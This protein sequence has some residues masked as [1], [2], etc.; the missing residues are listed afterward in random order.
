MKRGIVMEIKRRKAVILTED[1]RFEH[2]RIPKGK[3]PEIGD[4]VSVAAQGMG[5]VRTKGRKRWLPAISTFSAILIFVVLLGGFGP[6]GP[7]RTVAAYVSYDVN[8]S[9]SVAVNGRLQV[10]SVKTWNKDAANLFAGWHSYHLMGLADFSHLVVQKVAQRGYFGDHPQVLMATAVVAKDDRKKK[11]IKS[12]L[13]KEIRQI[14]TDPLVKKDH[15]QVSVKTGDPDIR[16][17]A[18]AHGLSLGKYLLY[19]DAEKSN[20]PLSISR[21]KKMSVAEIERDI[22]GNQNAVTLKQQKS[23]EK[24]R[25]PRLAN[26]VIV[27]KQSETTVSKQTNP[28]GNSKVSKQKANSA[29][30][31]VKKTS[32][33]VK[34]PEKKTVSDSSSADKSATIHQDKAKKL[35]PRY[36]KRPY[37][38]EN[39]GNGHEHQ[40]TGK[41]HNKNGTPP[42]S[43]TP[44]KTRPNPKQ[45]EKHKEMPPGKH[46][47]SI[48]HERYIKHIGNRIYERLD[49]LESRLDLNDL[50]G[51]VHIY[52]GQRARWIHIP[53]QSDNDAEAPR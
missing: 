41:D 45:P 39:I 28:S 8:P 36:K 20:K 17:K 5:F 2:I 37:R 9:F 31:K 29:G 23:G 48:Q 50:F 33:A 32:G 13:K 24:K 38:I 16:K 21:I 34:Q 43:P 44:H 15:V 10:V 35:D 7:D 26:A 53:S 42:A 30:K 27:E 51:L 47:G 22:K 14:R 6:L 52:I 11:K 25:E 49:H 19:L 4:T 18:N 40:K 1:G 3:T 12:L 46:E